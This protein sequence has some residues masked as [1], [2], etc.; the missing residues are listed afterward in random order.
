[1]CRRIDFIRRSGIIF[2]MTVLM[3]GLTL[4]GSQNSLAQQQKSWK[5]AGPMTLICYTGPGTAYDYLAR[6]IALVLPDYL[7]KPVM[8]QSVPGGGGGNA[9]DTVYHAKP[10]GRTF[11]LYGLGSQVA[12]ALEKRYKWDIKELNLILAIDAPPYGVL[13]SAKRS[14]YKDFKELMNTKETVRIGTGG[15]NF[16]IV[17]L[18]LELEKHGVK[19]RV[20]RF[21]DQTGAFLAVIAGDADI[22][23]SALSS[24][25]LDPIRAGDFRPLWVFANKRYSE[26][27]DVPTQVELGM[28]KEWSNFNL[29]RLIAMPPGVPTDIQKAFTEALIKTLQD[30]R[31][32]EWSKKAEIPVDI[33]EKKELDERVRIVQEGFRNNMEIVK[34]YF[35]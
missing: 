3:I 32:L 1:M 5:P 18:I 34:R 30:K 35:F 28:S 10:D 7:G 31:T 13:A 25:G 16:V 27:P 2:M 17:P 6:Q 12:L 23:M 24:I 15:A 4:V 26:L 21:K 19:Y 9:L 20:A 33:V 8:V 11:V 14:T 22:T 29:I